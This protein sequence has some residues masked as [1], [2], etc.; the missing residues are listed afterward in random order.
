[1][2]LRTFHYICFYLR[3]LFKTS[4]VNAF[5]A[6][7]HTTR[8]T[9]T[10]NLSRAYHYTNKRRAVRA[11]RRTIKE[12]AVSTCRF[13]IQ[14]SRQTPAVTPSRATARASRCRTAI[15]IR[16]RPQGKGKPPPFPAGAYPFRLVVDVST[17]SRAG[18]EVVR[19]TA[20]LALVAGQPQIVRTTADALGG[21][22]GSH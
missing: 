5:H 20:L 18:G 19:L 14:A 22:I 4:T 11:S 16:A 13:H 1:M 8:K 21:A 2:L 6:Y 7:I 15:R 10:V 12:Q 9:L 17:A 3:I